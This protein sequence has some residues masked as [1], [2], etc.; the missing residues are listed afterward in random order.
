MKARSCFQL[1]RNEPWRLS[2]L[3]HS[4]GVFGTLKSSRTSCTLET[5]QNICHKKK[6]VWGISPQCKSTLPPMWWYILWR[7]F[8]QF[9]KFTEM[10]QRGE[11]HN[12]LDINLFCF[13]TA[14][15][16]ILGNFCIEW[17]WRGL[18][19]IPLSFAWPILRLVKAH[20][21]YG[22]HLNWKSS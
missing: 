7:L 4:L 15:T 11:T 3:T 18:V 19:A 12:I 1:G 21:P 20:V 17:L 22:V 13:P 5:S 9:E 16:G 6:E 2:Q 8:R 14:S 10:S